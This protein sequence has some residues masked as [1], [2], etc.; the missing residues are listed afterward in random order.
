M[1]SGI[2]AR[3]SN[4]ALL[5][6]RK[7]SRG[8]L[9]PVVSTSPTVTYAPHT[10]KGIGRGHL[11]F[12]WESTLE[13]GLNMVLVMV[14]VMSRHV[15]CLKERVYAYRRRRIDIFACGWRNAQGMSLRVTTGIYRKKEGS[16]SHWLGTDAVGVPPRLRLRRSFL[17]FGQTTVA[18]QSRHIE[19]Q[20]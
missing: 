12:P 9:E 4:D 19:S 2:C 1:M 3:L 17:R 15:H 20:R 13:Y 11:F 16:V 14:M 5:P 10:L 6:A 7:A 18:F 8:G